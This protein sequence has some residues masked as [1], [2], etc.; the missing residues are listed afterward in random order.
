MEK[1]E[2]IR[3]PLTLIAIFAGLSEVSMTAVLPL[4]SNENQKVFMWFVMIYPSLLVC[5]FFY[6]LIWKREALYAPSDF[7]D[8]ATW[9]EVMRDKE[10]KIL[11]RYPVERAVAPKNEKEESD[12][13]N[14]VDSNRFY[15]LLRSLGLTHDKIQLIT[16]SV[17]NIDDVPQIVSTHT[18]N[19]NVSEKIKR[20]IDDFPASKDD[21]NKLKN[22]LQGGY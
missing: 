3:N 6:V 4:L 16:S 2:I 5:G 20:V 11:E 18:S 14:T 19:K 13:K 17:D 9:L 8:D 10:R 1:K 15:V 12:A 22:M 7:K 21:F